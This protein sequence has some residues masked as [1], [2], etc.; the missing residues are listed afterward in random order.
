M[1][2]IM[3]VLD[4]PSRLDEVLEAWSSAGVSGVTIMETI[5]AYRR[6]TRRVTGRY[7]FGLPGLAESAERSQYTLFAVVPD[8]KTADLCLEAS[9][10]VVGDLDEPNTGVFAS[11]KL[12]SAKGVPGR[13]AGLEAEE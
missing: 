9:E 6:H 4:D 1:H 5:G 11:W 7:V 3:L 8:R 13:A 10:R 2:M 12:S